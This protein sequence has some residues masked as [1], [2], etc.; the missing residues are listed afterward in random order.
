MF[1]RGVFPA[2]LETY[3]IAMLQCAK[4][5]IPSLEFACVNARR[6]WA[7]LD[8]SQSYTSRGRRLPKR[9]AAASRWL[10]L[11]FSQF[12]SSYFSRGCVLHAQA[13]R[14]FSK[15]SFVGLEPSL[16]SSL[17]KG[18]GHATTRLLLRMR[19]LFF[20]GG[21]GVSPAFF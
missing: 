20:T 6:P 10:F 19:N 2:N 18:D 15:V 14:Y 17:S 12:V 11:N 1:L 5:K 13:Y 7:R 3:H 21:K 9:N 4:R 8:I 16:G